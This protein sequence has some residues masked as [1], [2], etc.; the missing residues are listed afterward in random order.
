MATSFAQTS[1]IYKTLT[2]LW[3]TT[4]V[5]AFISCGFKYYLV[6]AYFWLEVCAEKRFAAV[7]GAEG[8]RVES[9]RNDGRPWVR[10]HGKCAMHLKNSLESFRSPWEFMLYFWKSRQH[11]FVQYR[12]TPWLNCTLILRRSMWQCQCPKG[13]SLWVTQGNIILPGKSVWR[14]GRPR[15]LL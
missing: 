13:S 15:P 3:Y 14:L 6:S 9:L 7:F 2:W 4:M 12:E 5:S 8:F 1:T 11:V 10:Q